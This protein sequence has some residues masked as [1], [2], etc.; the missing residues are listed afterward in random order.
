ML[1]VDCWVPSSERF[2]RGLDKRAWLG[3][4][5]EKNLSWRI[6]YLMSTICN[7]EPLYKSLQ[8]GPSGEQI[9][10]LRIHSSQAGSNLHRHNE[11]W[12]LWTWCS[13]APFLSLFTCLSN[14]FY[15]IFTCGSKLFSM[16]SRY[17]CS[18]LH[19]YFVQGPQSLVITLCGHEIV[20]GGWP[21]HF[22]IVPPDTSP[23]FVTLNDTWTTCNP[24][25]LMQ[26]PVTQSKLLGLKQTNML[27]GVPA[28]VI[29]QSGPT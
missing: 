18:H 28:F 7:L 3:F 12:S 20:L 9:T 6:C 5:A 21:Q 2:R 26:A 22:R 19:I 25:N 23:W 29:K 13:C 14:C 16:Q 24:S 15:T 1:E 17:L 8:L 10:T 11:D 4:R 27:L